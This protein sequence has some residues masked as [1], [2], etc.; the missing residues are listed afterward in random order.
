VLG[1]LVIAF[2]AGVAVIAVLL[3]LLSW[4]ISPPER[5]RETDE[6]VTDVFETWFRRRSATRTDFEPTRYG[7]IVPA[8]RAAALLR[9]CSDEEPAGI[10]AYWRPTRAM[11]DELEHRLT[12]FPL[13]ARL[14]ALDTYARQYGGVL[15][16]GRR[17]IYVSLLPGLSPDDVRRDVVTLCDGRRIVWGALFD[18]ESR[19]VSQ[20]Q[21]RD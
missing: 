5:T 3:A 15:G 2:V 10:A 6:S 11:I 9:Q 4:L 8:A 12:T 16:N 18:V 21:I 14:D 17:L 19:T 13:D 1:R 7:A 20:V